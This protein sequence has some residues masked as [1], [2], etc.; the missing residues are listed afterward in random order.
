[1]ERLSSAV[2]EHIETVR[3]PNFLVFHTTE[4]ICGSFRTVEYPIG[5]YS[6]RLTA[7][8]KSCEIVI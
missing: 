6:G 5:G 2:S 1:V 8:W 3:T 7:D 4:K